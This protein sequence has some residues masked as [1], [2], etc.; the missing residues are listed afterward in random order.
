MAKRK[1]SQKSE[2]HRIRGLNVNDPKEKE[3]LVALLVE[4]YKSSHKPMKELMEVPEELLENIYALAYHKYQRGEYDQAS[5]LFQYL[6]TFDERCYKYLLGLAACL[7]RLKQYEGAGNVYMMASLQKPTD[8]VAFYHAADCWIHEQNWPLAEG[9][10]EMA[11][12]ASS[13]DPKYKELGER[14]QLMLKHL[15]SKEELIK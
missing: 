15:K 1:K 14:A 12:R 6:L 7:H 4:E 2:E 11:I 5:S 9:A 3:K 10:L 8:P 13:V